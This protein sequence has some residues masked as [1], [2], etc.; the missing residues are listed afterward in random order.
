[1]SIE[2]CQWQDHNVS[3]MTCPRRMSPK[4]GVTSIPY[5]CLPL[6]IKENHPIVNFLFGLM[7]IWSFYTLRITFTIHLTLHFILPC[8]PYIYFLVCCSCSDQRTCPH[9]WGHWEG[10]AK[11]A[12]CPQQPPGKSRNAIG[13]WTFP[14]V[15]FQIWQTPPGIQL[16]N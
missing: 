16:G 11:C 12:S 7:Y 8:F 3:E 6:G 13:W 5:Y 10:R 2:S 1:M 15:C 14:D 9:S 4:S